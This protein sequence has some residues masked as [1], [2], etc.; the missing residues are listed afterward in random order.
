M[1]AFETLRARGF[2]K[3]HTEGAA[4]LL[5]QGP[6]TVY[7]GFDPTAPSLHIGHLLPVMMLAHLQRLGHRPIALIGGATAMIGDPTGRDEARRILSPETIE[8]NKAGLRAQLGRFLD[9]SSDSPALMLD[10]AD[11]LCSFGYINFLREVGVH[12]PMMPM[13]NKASVKLRL[14]K[15]MSFLEFNY[16]LLQGYDFL[17]LYR[18]QG[19]TLQVGGDD[20][21][22]NIVSGVE[23]IRRVEGVRVQAITLP[24]LTTAEGK[25]MGKTAG[26]AVWLSSSYTPGPG[27]KPVTPYDF[28]QYWLNVDDRDVGRFLRLF[29]FL[30]LEEIA[31][32]EALQGAEIRAAKRALALEATAIVHGREAADRAAQGQVS[33]AMPTH[34]AALPERLV[35]VLADAGLCRSRGEARRKIAGGAVRL[36]ADRAERVEDV[37][38]VLGPE[39]LTEDGSVVLWCGRKKAV[40]IQKA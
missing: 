3:Q 8:A 34:A 5:A 29:T 40:R 38:A 7:A 11:W 33:A 18:R 36:G 39:R 30:P 24:L 32:L 22:G 35:V 4:A 10:N 9:F 20:Q 6:V 16:Q 28:Y 1:D 26:G 15:G 21:W 23:L 25:K 31:R 13:L 17:E 14:E 2:I 12:F 37:D 19:C 27:D